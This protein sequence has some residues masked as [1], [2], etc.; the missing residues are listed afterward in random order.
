MSIIHLI[1]GVP[2]FD[3]YA[4]VSCL[5]L[6]VAKYSVGALWSAWL[7][8]PLVPHGFQVRCMILAAGLALSRCLVYALGLG[9]VAPHLPT[10]CLADPADSRLA[11][12]SPTWL[13]A[14][15]HLQMLSGCFGLHLLHFFKYHISN[16]GTQRITANLGETMLPPC[17]G[18]FY[19]DWRYGLVLIRSYKCFIDFFLYA[20]PCCQD[21]RRQK[22]LTHTPTTVDGVVL[23]L[24]RPSELGSADIE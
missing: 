21:V 12:L 10:L 24:A 15:S 14:V 5:S 7:T 20:P 6:T 11:C 8:L 1:I 22:A 19:T 3:L 17:L 13:P 16:L 2:D 9:R 23:E 18:G 4:L